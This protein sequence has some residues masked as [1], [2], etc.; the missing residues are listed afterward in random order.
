MTERGDGVGETKKEREGV[1]KGL[2]ERERWG[3]G[4][5]TERHKAERI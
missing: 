5:G 3:G 4:E 1:G 2:R